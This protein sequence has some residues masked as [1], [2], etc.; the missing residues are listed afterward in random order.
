M[1]FVAPY[2]GRSNFVH[3]RTL[4]RA[5]NL[6]QGTKLTPLPR[7]TRVANMK[8]KRTPP[9]LHGG[10][11]VNTNNKRYKAHKSPNTNNKRYKAHKSPPKMRMKTEQEVSETRCLLSVVF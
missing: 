5:L 6:P 7:E 4:Q 1:Y 3:V 10:V 9:K 2:A 8:R 11:L